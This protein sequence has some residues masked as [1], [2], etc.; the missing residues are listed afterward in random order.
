MTFIRIRLFRRPHCIIHE[1]ILGHSSDLSDRIA[2]IL[3]SGR[4][5]LANSRPM[6][7]YRRGDAGLCL[8][9]GLSGIDAVERLTRLGRTNE[10]RF[11]RTEKSRAARPRR[12]RLHERFL[13]TDFRRGTYTVRRL[14]LTLGARQTLESAVRRSRAKHPPEQSSLARGDGEPENKIHELMSADVRSGRGHSPVRP[15]ANRLSASFSI[16]RTRSRVRPSDSPISFS[17]RGSPS[18]RPNRIRKIVASRGSMSS[19]IS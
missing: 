8:T 2:V 4:H 10:R 6:R 16:C 19:S 13:E 18:S 7:D 15:R 3:K 11:G 5:Q 14:A 17:V 1:T 12:D 9:C